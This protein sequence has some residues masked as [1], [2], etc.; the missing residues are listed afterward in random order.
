MGKTSPMSILGERLSLAARVSRAKNNAL[1][2]DLQTQEGEVAAEAR[3]KGGAAVLFGFK[4]GGKGNY[5]VDAK[6][7]HLDVAVAAT[8]SVTRDGEQLGKIL[9]L[10]TAAR[11][12]DAGGTVLADIN[13]HQGSKADA[14]WTHALTAPGGAS[15]GSITLMRNGTGWGDFLLWTT[16][17]DMAVLSLKTPSAGALLQLDAPVD[18]T[19]SDLLAAACVDVCVLPRGYIA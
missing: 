15:I 19:L 12:V 4:N 14:A 16:T 1:K 2:V 9:G 13:P 7:V 5:T 6:G 3:Q 18:D 17:W 10:G 11:I 8:T